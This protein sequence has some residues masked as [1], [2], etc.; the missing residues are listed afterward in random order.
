[1]NA[2]DSLF[3]FGSYEIFPVND[4]FDIYHI[5]GLRA[6]LMAAD[7]LTLAEAIKYLRNI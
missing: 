2:G 5:E 3:K 7:F 4:M 6:E 1:M